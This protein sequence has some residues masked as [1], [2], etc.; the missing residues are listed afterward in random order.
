KIGAINFETELKILKNIR[1]RYSAEKLILRVDANGAFSPSEAPKKLEQLAQLELHS[2]E[3]PIKAR[4]VEAMYELCQTTPL[5]IALD[6]E[7]IGIISR[8]EKERL[9]DQIQPQ[10]IILKPTLV[11]GIASTQEWIEIAEARNINWWITSALE[12]NIGLNAIAQLTAEYN[13]TLPQGLGTGQL[14]E[15][16]IESPLQV[17]AGRIWY[18]GEWGS[19]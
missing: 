18:E 13:P 2:I 7:L 10:F 12:S 3:Q 8:S 5:P 15:N 16:N 9:L 14:Y 6:E 19:F 4:Q 17:K 11:G 1:A